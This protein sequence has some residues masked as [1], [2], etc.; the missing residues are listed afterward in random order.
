MGEP[1]LCGTGPAASLGILEEAGD[2]LVEERVG[3]LGDRHRRV[4]P[5]GPGLRLADDALDDEAIGRLG[6]QDLLQAALVHE[7]TDGAQDL[8]VV[9]ART[10][11]VDAHR[12]P[13]WISQ[14]STSVPA[15]VAGARSPAVSNADDSPAC[16]GWQ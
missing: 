11:F 4:G 12:E 13:P 2:V 16:A 15:G 3:L 7:G 1:S 10:T 9:L 14:S 6:Q 8:L 5:G